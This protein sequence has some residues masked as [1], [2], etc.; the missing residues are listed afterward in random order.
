MGRGK[1]T[2][3]TIRTMRMMRTGLASVNYYVLLRPI[4]SARLSTGPKREEL[5]KAV[6]MMMLR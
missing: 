1:G 3:R 6:E 4:V 2:K 5:L